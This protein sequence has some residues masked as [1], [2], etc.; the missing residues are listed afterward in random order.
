MNWIT[1]KEYAEKQGIKLAAAYKRIYDN[2]VE[3]K[4]IYGKIVVKNK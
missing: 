4:K 1:V 3:S 2:N